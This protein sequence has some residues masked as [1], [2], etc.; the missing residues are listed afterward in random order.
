MSLDSSTL[1]AQVIDATDRFCERR[2]RSGKVNFHIQAI[3]TAVRERR[4]QVLVARD[5]YQTC[6]HCKRVIVG[7]HY[8][9]S[10]RKGGPVKAGKKTRRVLHRECAGYGF[11]HQVDTTCINPHIEAKRLR[12]EEA[13][14]YRDQAQNEFVD[15][16]WNFGHAVWLHYLEILKLL[17]TW[18][19]CR[20]RPINIGANKPI[21]YLCA[22]EIDDESYTCGVTDYLLCVKK[23]RKGQRGLHKACAEKWVGEN[24]WKNKPTVKI[25][26]ALSIKIRFESVVAEAE[27]KVNELHIE[28]KSAI[29][30]H[31]NYGVVRMNSPRGEST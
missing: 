23:I 25:Q 17:K 2:V 19:F 9:Y 15:A 8:D 14:S 4:D 26:S 29:S 6:D 16:N 7:D 22:L 27:K 28:L 11:R 30:N 31:L 5:F 24:Q 10:H 1:G 18:H 13:I 3:A 12:L 20:Q 21:C